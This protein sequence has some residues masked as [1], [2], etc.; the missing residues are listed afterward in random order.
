MPQDAPPNVSPPMTLAAAIDAIESTY[1]LMLAYAAQGRAREDDD[2]MGVRRS[3]RN[4]LTAIDTIQ[5]AT[6]TSA[7]RRPR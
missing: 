1:E 3:L 2:P 5:A 6:P 7:M 4:A